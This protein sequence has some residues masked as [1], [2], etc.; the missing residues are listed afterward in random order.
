MCIH[1]N[2]QWLTFIN[3]ICCVALLLQ[4][5]VWQN[6]MLQKLASLAA[7]VLHEILGHEAQILLDLLD[8]PVTIL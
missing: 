8:E 5:I 2:K 7:H 6:K 1:L 4:F 3:D